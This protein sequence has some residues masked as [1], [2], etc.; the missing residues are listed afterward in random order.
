MEAFFLD[1]LNPK[2]KAFAEF[3]AGIF[4][5]HIK[6]AIPF[7][8]FETVLHNPEIIHFSVESHERNMQSSQTKEMQYHFLM[9]ES[10]SISVTQ[11]EADYIAAF[12]C[13]LS[14]PCPTPHIRFFASGP[15]LTVTI[16]K[17]VD[18]D[19]KIRVVFQGKDAESQASIFSNEQPRQPMIHLGPKREKHF[20]QSFPQIGSDEVGTGDF[21]GPIVVCAAF[22]SEADVDKLN[23][24]GVT[25]SKKMSDDVILSIGPE[26]SLSFPHSLLVL[27]NAKYNDVISSG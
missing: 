7:E 2:A 26:L 17:K 14:L 22:V 13:N 21:F 6:K 8:N 3:G 4:R 12:Y 1:R 19:G 23:S 15:S 5:D 11:R 25:D 18:K 16:Y 20:V 24:L 9:Q 27:R 10:V